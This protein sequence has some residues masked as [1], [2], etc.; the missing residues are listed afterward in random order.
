MHTMNL[1]FAFL[2]GGAVATFLLSLALIEGMRREGDKELQKHSAFARLI[3]AIVM[4]ALW[5]IVDVALALP[6][7]LHI[8]DKDES[9]SD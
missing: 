6:F 8:H 7:A 3:G 5:P 4:A 1:I 9:E 2:I